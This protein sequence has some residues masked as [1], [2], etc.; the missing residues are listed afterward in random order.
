MTKGGPG[1]A[2]EVFPMLIYRTGLKYFNLGYASAMGF[3]LL[4]VE[5]PLLMWIIKRLRAIF[6]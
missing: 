1:N 2:T 4:I 3:I 5:I 6:D